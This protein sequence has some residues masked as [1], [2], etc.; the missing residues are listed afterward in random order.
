[1]LHRIMVDFYINYIGKTANAL[2][3]IFALPKGK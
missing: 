1:M 3:F 2:P